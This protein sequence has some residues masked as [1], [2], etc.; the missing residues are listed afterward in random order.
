MCCLNIVRMVISPRSPHSFGIL[1]VRHDV[2][3]VGEFFVADRTLPV[4]LDDFPLQD[5]PHLC[6]RSELSIPSRVMWIFNTLHAGSYRS[7]LGNEFPA[8][9]GNRFVNRTEFV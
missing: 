7:W 3:V 9:A 8:T 2:V 6:R 1:V 5:F 4:L